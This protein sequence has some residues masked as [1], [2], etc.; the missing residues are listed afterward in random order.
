MR[1]G[2]SHE[3][4]LLYSLALSAVPHSAVHTPW[5]TLVTQPSQC[6]LNLV[7]G[8]KISHCPLEHSKRARHD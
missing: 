6:P 4:N 3:G 7:R 2:P 8:V 1:D 5:P